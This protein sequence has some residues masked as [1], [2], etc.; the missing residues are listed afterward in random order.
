MRNDH[1]TATKQEPED[2]NTYSLFLHCFGIFT[3]FW[4]SH[5]IKN[6]CIFVAHP[7]N[8][9]HQIATGSRE[10]KPGLCSAQQRRFNFVTSVIRKVKEASSTSTEGRKTNKPQRQEKS[11]TIS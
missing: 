11:D 1:V 2:R 7:R 6:I 3:Q 4:I 9:A 5:F 8:L 10:R